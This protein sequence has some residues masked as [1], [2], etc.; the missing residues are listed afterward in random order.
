TFKQLGI[1]CKNIGH[2]IVHVEETF[3]EYSCSC[4][5]WMGLRVWCP[6]LEESHISSSC[7]SG[8]LRLHEHQQDLSQA[9]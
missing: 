3:V 4:L 9:N 8:R 2:D 6:N 1:G 5:A 7:G